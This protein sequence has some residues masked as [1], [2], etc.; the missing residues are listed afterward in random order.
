MGANTSAPRQLLS[1]GSE[2]GGG[3]GGKASSFL[4][5]SDFVSSVKAIFKGDFGNQ[6]S[7]TRSEDS[8]F[9]VF[10]QSGDAP[11]SDV[12]SKDK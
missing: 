2:G 1:R 10:G 3:G 6:C 4:E 9:S 8:G 7:C 5:Q 12:A 11:K